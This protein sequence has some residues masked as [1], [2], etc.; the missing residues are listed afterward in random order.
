MKGFK[1][2]IECLKKYNIIDFQS[3]ETISLFMFDNFIDMKIHLNELYARL[4][5]SKFNKISTQQ[6]YVSENEW[7][8]I[9]YIEVDNRLDCYFGLDSLKAV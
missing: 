3:N 8:N 1:E 7:Y 6:T 4:F 2:F 5:K 9:N